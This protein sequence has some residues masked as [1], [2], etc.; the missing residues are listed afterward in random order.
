MSLTANRTETKKSNPC[1]WNNA[2]D[3]SDCETVSLHRNQCM[4]ICI[5]TKGRCK[6]DATPDLKSEI[7]RT[8]DLTKKDSLIRAQAY[9]NVMCHQHGKS[10]PDRFNDEVIQELRLL[11][12][13]MDR[14]A[15]DVILFALDENSEVIYNDR[16][17][18]LV[19]LCQ[20]GYF[21]I[22]ELMLVDTKLMDFDGQ[23][24]QEMVL[25]AL[26]NNHNKIIT[27]LLKN[28]LDINTLFNISG[29]SSHRQI[30]SMT[31]LEYTCRYN[32]DINMIQ[33]LLDNI[34]KADL[35]NQPRSVDSILVLAINNENVNK[36]NKYKLVQL[37]LD[38]KADVNGPG[39]LFV[40]NDNLH[41]SHYNTPLA[42][43]ANNSDDFDIVELLI[44]RNAIVDLID[45]DM[46]TALQLASITGTNHRVVSL[47]VENKAAVDGP[48]MTMEHNIS[49]L[50]LA[51]QNR[52]DMAAISLICAG[53]RNYGRYAKEFT[54]FVTQMRKDNAIGLFA[55]NENR[56]CR[57]YDDEKHMPVA[58]QDI[59]HQYLDYPD[60]PSED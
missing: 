50:V 12:Q 4:R 40:D 37:L 18:S 55:N 32:G 47:L 23:H 43:A 60:I 30:F 33:L 39:P 2:G 14:D 56:E 27:I 46:N 54:D 10:I 58:V 38:S 59:I 48:I 9:N 17:D 22:L 51:I 57:L 34:N 1:L 20:N 42:S 11:N 8:T 26:D 31:M 21:N 52:N 16:K 35:N 28:Q 29:R 15:V 44:Q 7:E 25:N 53:A 19:T 36:D 45:G 3:C 41:R 49:P 6:R 24:I 5:T 13:H